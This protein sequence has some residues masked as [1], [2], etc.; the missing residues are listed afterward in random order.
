MEG[1]VKM[2]KSTIAIA[3]ISI[4]FFFSMNVAAET[5]EEYKVKDPELNVK[6]AKAKLASVK[7]ALDDYTLFTETILTDDTMAKLKS[8]K[9]GVTVLVEE[10]NL[11]GLS[12]INWST[13]NHGFHNWLLVLRGTLL[14]LDYLTK[15][16]EYELAKCRGKL[17][18]K[19][20]VILEKAVNDS[21]KEY[22]QFL[23]KAVYS[24]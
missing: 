24:D 7:K 10:K 2:K 19:E 20:L 8:E 18:E 13:Q 23:S 11:K 15:K 22:Q 3:V 12:T 4:S 9:T 5:P 14:K 17:S 16:N 6:A 1:E 21:L